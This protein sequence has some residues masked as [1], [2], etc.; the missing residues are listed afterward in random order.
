MYSRPLT[1]PMKA[2]LRMVLL[3]LFKISIFHKVF[4]WETWQTPIK[5]QTDTC[6]SWKE[7]Q[8][9]NSVNQNIPQ[10]NIPEN[11][12]QKIPLNITQVRQG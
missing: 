1:K 12:S 5:K 7:I 2:I 6:F 9:F 8:L 11:L 4:Y 3:R 10:I